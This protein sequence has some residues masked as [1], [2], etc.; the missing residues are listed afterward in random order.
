MAQ[1]SFVGEVNFTIK[2]KFRMD[3]KFSFKYVSENVSEK[4]LKTCPQTNLLLDRSQLKY[5]KAAT[6]VR[7]NLQNVLTKPLQKVSG[8]FKTLT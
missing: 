3:K 8:Y 4:L 5:W 1:N 6:Y 7:Q 2:Q